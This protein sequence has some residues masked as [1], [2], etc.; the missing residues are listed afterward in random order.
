M[1]RSR[2]TSNKHFQL[3][4]FSPWLLELPFHPAKFTS[5]V[6][7]RQVVTL[8]NSR[9]FA[10]PPLVSPRRLRNERRNSILMTCHYHSN[11]CSAS[12]WSCLEGNRSI[13][14]ICVMTRHQYG[15]SVVAISR[16]NQYA[17]V[18]KCRL[19]SQ[20]TQVGKFSFLLFH[21]L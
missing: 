8:E 10:T 1:R 7:S 15:I 4:V 16:G 3:V 18:A 5:E 11:P 9:H 12:D 2:F 17:G 20:A 13:T 6:I 19:F 14:Q 21:A